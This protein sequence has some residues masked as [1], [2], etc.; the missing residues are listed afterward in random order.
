MTVTAWRGR[1]RR[2]GRDPG[3]ARRSAAVAAKA[4]WPLL[5]CTSRVLLAGQAPDGEV[6]VEL[7]LIALGV[8]D[9]DKEP[10]AG[11]FDGLAED[12]AA[13]SFN[14]CDGPRRPGS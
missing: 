7:D 1:R 8:G 12:R 9:G 2:L 3:R 6:L 4:R 10:D 11:E 5:D 14:L 13:G